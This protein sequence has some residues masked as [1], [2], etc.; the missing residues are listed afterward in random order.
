MPQPQIV[1]QLSGLPLFQGMSLNDLNNVTA[2]TKL[3]FKTVS[4]GKTIVKAGEQCRC[5]YMLMSG[6]AI[7][8]STADDNSY[9]LRETVAAPAL[10]QPE[11]L[12]GLSQRHT[13]TFEATTPCHLIYINKDEVLQLLDSYEIFKLN[14]MNILCTMTQR[15]Q[16][17]AWRKKPEGISM[18]IGH[19]VE[20]RSIRPAGEKWLSI[21]MQKLGKEIGESRLN[22]SHELKRMAQRGW[23]ETGRGEIRIKALEAL[24]NSK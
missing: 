10:L 9:T 5:L 6:K 21:T 17:P 12:F 19:F 8:T 1:N 24:L 15:S 23:I 3:G 16:R 7:A 11:H 4:G 13:K 20:E 14:M 18:K 2:R 22:V